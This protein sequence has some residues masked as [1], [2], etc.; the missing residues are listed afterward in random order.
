MTP[1]QS[2]KTVPETARQ[3][4]DYSPNFLLGPFFQGGGH[5]RSV[6]VANL[7]GS[8]RFPSAV[9]MLRR[10][11]SHWNWQND[12]RCNCDNDMGKGRLLFQHSSYMVLPSPPTQK[13]LS[14]IVVVTAKPP[15]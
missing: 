3:K 6:I 7:T 13:C 15:M 4:S 5:L 9:G 10:C 14:H 11:S 1:L 12:C 8:E 2:Q